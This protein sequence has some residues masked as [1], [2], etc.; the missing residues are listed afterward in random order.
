MRIWEKYK[1]MKKQIDNR[2]LT[3]PFSDCKHKYTGWFGHQFICGDCGV[4]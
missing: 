1:I 2:E 3:E 4:V